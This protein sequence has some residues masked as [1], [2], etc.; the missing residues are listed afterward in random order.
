MSINKYDE[1]KFWEEVDIL[2][3]DIVKA[4]TSL[5]KKSYI[6]ITNL[7]N[8]VTWWSEKAMEY[9]GMQENYTIRGQEKSKRSIH[10][11]DL[12]DF[13]RGFPGE[14]CG[15]KYGRALGI[16]GAGRKYLQPDQCQGE[17]AE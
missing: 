11:D 13:R 14:S 2:F 8:G 4:I 9:F 16:P 10:S 5:A 15:K 12:E 17:N 7:R 3:P 6:S 1:Q